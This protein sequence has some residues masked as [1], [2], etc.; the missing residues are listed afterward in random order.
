MN[1]I[2][3]Q[4]RQ[5]SRKVV[6]FLVVVSGFA[7]STVA[8]RM[9]GKHEE[10]ILASKFDADAE[11]L[12]GNLVRQLEDDQ[13]S[14]YRL[15]RFLADGKSRGYDVFKDTAGE[16]VIETG[17]LVGAFW[18]RAFDRLAQTLLIS[19]S[20]HSARRGQAGRSLRF[21]WGPGSPR[22]IIP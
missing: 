6:L 4:S 8:F 13:S 1:A 16:I 11:R 12:Y 20:A 3:Q 7:I 9:V 2:V 10:G 15:S 22:T 19:R 14:V 17:N 5:A 18:K 21:R